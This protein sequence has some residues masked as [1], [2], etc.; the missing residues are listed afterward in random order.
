MT[1]ELD[2]VL[3]RE[4]EIEPSQVFARSVMA[5]V[6]R[7]AAEPP[8]IPFPWRRALPGMV[9]AIVLCALAV[10]NAFSLA[11]ATRTP[12]IPAAVEALVRAASTP[13]AIW[14]MVGLVVSAASIAVASV[15]LGR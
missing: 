11:S 4:P 5:A 15:R 13:Q 7:A 2:R 9:L 10:A 12:T 14:T 3:S 1:D 6:N 8:P